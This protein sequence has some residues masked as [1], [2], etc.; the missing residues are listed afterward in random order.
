M[1]TINFLFGIHNHQ[2]VGNFPE[3]LEKAYQDSYGPFLEVMS[4][5]PKIKWSLHCT[6]ILWDFLCERH[7]EYVKSVQA[8][9]EA[10]Q[11]EVM[12]GGYYEPIMPIIPDRDKKGQIDKLSAF[13]ERKFGR[14]PRG[15]WLAERVWEP[16]LA[17]ALSRSGMEYTVV[18]DAHFAAAGLDVNRLR[19]YYLTEEQGVKLAIFPISQRLRYAIPFDTVDKVISY[20]GECADESGRAA[21]VMADDGE[22]FGLWPETHKHVYTNGWLD[23][24]LE[25]VERNLE[26][27][28][29]VTFSEYLSAH[30][31]EG[32]VY[33]PTASYFEMSEWSLPSDA[34]EAF[35]GVVKQYEGKPHIKRF[36]RGGFWRNFLTKYAES[37]NMHKK[38]LYVSEKV[39]KAGRAGK[40][41]LYAGQCN[42]AYWHGVFGGLYL[43][44]LRNAVYAKLLEA[45]AAASAASP[46]ADIKTFDF[47]CDG[48][49]ETL[50]ESAGQNLYFSP[51]RGGALFE[52]DLPGRKVNLLNVLTRRQ[53]SYH[54]RLREFLANP[55]RVRGV[56]TI[57]DMVKVKEG[58][59][60]DHLH[61]DWYRRSSLIDHFL[62]PDTA[63][64]GFRRCQYGEQGDFVLGEYAVHADGGRVS[65]SRDGAVWDNDRRANVRVEKEILPFAGGLKVRY[66][67]TNTG[68]G[69]AALV[70]APEFNF[71]FS[72]RIDSE[73][74][75]LEKATKWE[76][77]DDGFGFKMTM[78]LSKEAGIWTFPLETVSLSEG[79]FE[80]TYQ[81]TV[82]LPI[83][84][85]KLA[86]GGHEDFD[87]S[88]EIGDKR[89]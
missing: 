85:M 33:L 64:E 89:P 86:K 42:C 31:A 82:V 59:L 46:A 22:K 21:L 24:F 34:Q 74:A 1:R 4:R 48:R 30:P 17:A 76:R 61:Y 38:M 12:G 73:T 23:R 2:P 25:A 66:A 67:V 49:E 58:N 54:A 77:N 19:G 16:S 63:F 79:G 51:H 8:M 83:W 60:D 71:A 41:A 72:Y 80:R 45:E 3:V 44:H 29:P 87:I 84:K 75:A 47:D 11:L 53:E 57:H 50:Y 27:I 55:H 9:A 18:D 52:W 32:S 36:L 10:G 78:E 65:L 62:H 56:R 35:E 81:G 5:H 70:F 15:M 68:D 43:P 26:W 39:R 14:R 6:G 40:D 69:D 20:F 13:I 37:N 88:I 28:K 7:P